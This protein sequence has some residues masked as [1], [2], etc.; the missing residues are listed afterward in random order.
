MTT[1]GRPTRV[2]DTGH[3]HWIIVLRWYF[4]IVALANLAWETL[5]LP[6][7]TVWSEATSEY[8]VFVVLHC[9]GGD[10][11]IALCALMAAL[12]LVAPATW[13]RDGFRRVA[14]VATVA[15]VGYTIFSEWLN[16]VVRKSWQYSELMPVVPVF[17]VGLSPLLQWI[18]LPPAALWLARRIPMHVER[19]REPTGE[20]DV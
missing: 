19:S 12:L 7:Y 18:L 10:V 5:H 8:L 15:G 2:P 1:D 13:P 9:T 17:D 3:P 6:L 11:L 14:T 4:P 20:K 16:L